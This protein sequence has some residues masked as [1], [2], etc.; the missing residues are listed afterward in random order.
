MNAANQC[1]HD[2]TIVEFGLH[3]SIGLMGTT[4]RQHR[5]W[6]LR[7]GA[8]G[9]CFGTMVIYY[10]R[11]DSGRERIRESFRHTGGLSSRARGLEWACMR[12]LISSGNG[13]VRPGLAFE[14]VETCEQRI[15]RPVKGVSGHLL[16]RARHA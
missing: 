3:K 16:A 4:P 10:I 8:G 14:K 6:P 7:A 1:Q 15:P 12:H 2:E 11:R 5:R 9:S 13:L